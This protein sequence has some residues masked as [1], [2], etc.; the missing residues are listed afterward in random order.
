MSLRCPL[1]AKDI[2]EG[3]QA[4]QRHI[5]RSQG[6][7]LM[8]HGGNMPRGGPPWR[9][10]NKGDISTP[11]ANGCFSRNREVRHG[12]CT[13]AGPRISDDPRPAHVH[14]PSRSGMKGNIFMINNSSSESSLVDSKLPL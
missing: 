6:E 13:I 12:L 11:L 8:Y 14:N 5:R 4:Q 3:G 2:Q 7:R 9:F 1:P 10:P